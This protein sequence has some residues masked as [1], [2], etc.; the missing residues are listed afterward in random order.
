MSTIYN[1]PTYLSTHTFIP[2]HMGDYANYGLNMLGANSIINYNNDNWKFY[3]F[4][5]CSDNA[6]YYN[7]AGVQLILN[8]RN[9]PAGI[10]RMEENTTTYI[11]V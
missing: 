7:K 11:F 3:A 5:G 1:I 6:I 9:M 4:E 10:T 8:T 2:H